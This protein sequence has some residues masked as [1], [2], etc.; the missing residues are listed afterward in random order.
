MS[1]MSFRAVLGLA[2]VVAV[3]S[4]HDVS[5]AV[6]ATEAPRAKQA[7]ANLDLAK[8]VERLDSSSFREREQAQQAL[9]QLPG[10]FA[11]KLEQMREA[12]KSPEIRGRLEQVI[13]SRRRCTWNS[14]LAAVD[15]AGCRWWQTLCRR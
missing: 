10:V 5:D 4:A 7:H 15:V 11:H 14:L 1:V 8:L 9:L 13:T 2:V 12:A 6:D 3:V